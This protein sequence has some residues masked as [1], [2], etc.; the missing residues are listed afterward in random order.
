MKS[1]KVADD[2]T[3]RTII[4]PDDPRGYHGYVPA[5][6]GVHTT[7]KTIEEVKENLRDAITCHVE[8]LLKD[9]QSVP[10]D[11]DSIELIQTFSANDFSTNRAY[12]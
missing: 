3:F 5:L 7:G 10:K 2:Y 8:G 1:K 9:K 4:E 11:N 6:P 12:A